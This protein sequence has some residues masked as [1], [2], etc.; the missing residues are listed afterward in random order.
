MV[1]NKKLM[2][3]QWQDGET[4]KRFQMI[5]PLLD[6]SLDAAK[7]LQM[8]RE[9]AKK[10]N[11]SERTVRRYISSYRQG[12]F[13][14]LK[15]KAREPHYHGLAP[16]NLDDLVAEAIQLRREVPTRSVEQI[17]TI[18]EMERKVTPGAL[19]RSTL[20]RHMQEAGFSAS[21]MQ[22]Y[23]EARES[24]SRRFCKPN[25][26]M[27]IQGDIKYGPKL[28]IGK[29]GAK[30]Q[31]YLS[32]A[33]DDHSRMVL[34]SQF[35]DN[36]EEAIVADTFRKAILKFG[37]FDSC[38]FDNG[39][40]YV[41]KQLK[42]SLA[43]LSI[44]VSHAPIKSGKSKGKVEKFHQVVDDFIAEA[45]AKK[46]STLEELNRYWRIFLDE[47]YH[48]K[49]HDGI[50]EYYEGLGV[51]I[52]PAGITPVQEFERDTRPLTFL[53]VNVVG[54]A[55]LYHETRK[56]DKGACISFQGKKYE[57]R[58]SLIGQTVE[59]SYDPAAPET[60]TVRHPGVEPFTAQPLKAG[61]YCGKK[62]PLP[63][64]MQEVEP[65]TSRF[66]DALEKQ[67]RE[68]RRRFAD[69]ISFGGYRKEAGE[70]DTN[71]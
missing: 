69:A 56:V 1:T 43:R 44:R 38:Y 58:P 39:S 50:R 26:M 70:V 41:A 8:K 3:V 40:Q 11:V 24:S 31:T 49:P 53:D 66:L 52:P 20:Q 62:S 68:S 35:Y 32:S 6:D 55:F 22:V 17:I 65:E 37:R 57:T 36:Q 63:A 4:L 28:P 13:D 48:K 45:K 61:S 18:L 34:H 7:A 14:G 64:S 5:A 46:V 23:R 47:Y 16:G 33:L 15:P 10:H 67:H 54:E 12:G 2:A 25:R 29:N 60:V 19:K 59:I 27:L 30:V 51:S 71:V 42:L 9:I 21:Q